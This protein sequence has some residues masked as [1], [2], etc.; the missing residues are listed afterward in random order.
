[1]GQ[2]GGLAYLVGPGWA[3]ASTGKTLA[4]AAEVRE[5]FIDAEDVL[6]FLIFKQFWDKVS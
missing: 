2:P 3:G 6:E 1:L 5:G 4:K